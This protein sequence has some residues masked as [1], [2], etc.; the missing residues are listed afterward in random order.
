[1]HGGSIAVLVQVSEFIIIGGAG[2]GAVLIGNSWSVVKRIMRDTV[3]LLKPDPFGRAANTELLRVL[4]ELFY[5]ARR[6]GLIGV[7]SHVERPEESELFK[8][9]PTF[10]KNHHAVSFLADTM[11]VLL[12]GT[13]GDHHLAEILDLDLEQYQE[14]G[15]VVPHAIARIGDAMPGFGIVAAVLGVIIT[16]GKI[17]GEPAAIGESVAAA[18]VGTFLGVLLAY[19]VFG[20]VAQQ[21]EGRVRSEHDYMRSIR[22][23]VLS[24]ARG[25]APLTSIEFARRSI[26]PEHRPSFVEV[27]ALTSAEGMA[28]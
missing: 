3:S 1:M 18:L 9:Y 6:D 17:G 24:F 25:D 27:E 26:P 12:S 15:L 19:A 22:T 8:K 7:E 11:K 20:P 5:V 14:E 13:V 16:M 28:S 10:A 2:L 23:A 21:L 4:Y